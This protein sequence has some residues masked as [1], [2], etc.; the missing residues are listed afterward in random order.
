MTA[1]MIIEIFVI[2]LFVIMPNLVKPITE[3]AGT[4]RIF[5]LQDQPIGDMDDLA[6]IVAAHQIRKLTVGKSVN[7]RNCVFICADVIVFARFRQNREGKF[8][9]FTI[10]RWIFLGY[11]AHCFQPV[12]SG[13]F[14]MVDSIRTV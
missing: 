14:D 13:C 10:E 5:C 11:D 8:V 1:N 12:G 9:D 4:V 2:S 6:R 7:I 3:A